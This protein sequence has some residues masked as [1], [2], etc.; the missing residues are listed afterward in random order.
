MEERGRR[1]L[2][3]ARGAL[4][5]NHM[6][7]TRDPQPTTFVSVTS[8]KHDYQVENSNSTTPPPPRCSSCCT[9]ASRVQLERQ[10]WQINTRLILKPLRRQLSNVRKPT[11]TEGRKSHGPSLFLELTDN[12]S[13]TLGPLSPW[14]A[15][16]RP[17]NPLGRKRAFL[18]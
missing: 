8:P 7:G 10:L 1:C 5:T 6:P 11:Q 14:M 15:S 13:L 4:S 3:G 9:G 2:P 18:A 12:G 17:S 16:L